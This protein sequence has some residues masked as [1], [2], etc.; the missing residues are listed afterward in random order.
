MK[1]E[2]PCNKQ[3]LSSVGWQAVQHEVLIVVD[4]FLSRSAYSNG[5]AF[6]F[7][8]FFFWHLQS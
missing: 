1:K 2:S 8:A 5:L 3:E 6:G 7:W 4:S